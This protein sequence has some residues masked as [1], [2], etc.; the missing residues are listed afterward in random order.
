MLPK[1]SAA[2]RKCLPCLQVRALDSRPS[3]VGNPMCVTFLVCDRSQLLTKGQVRQY[4]N[5]R[6]QAAVGSMFCLM[7]FLRMMDD[8]MSSKTGSVLQLKV[9]L[10]KISPM[11][12]QRML[13][14]I[15]G[16]QALQ[17]GKGGSG[18]RDGGRFTPN[19]WV[20]PKRPGRRLSCVVPAKDAPNPLGSAPGI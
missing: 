3:I 13:A 17:R 9:R 2:R 4:R 11:I 6:G 16:P 15:L 7:K 8:K 1:K 14:P 20:L 12:W 18:I 5:L 19:S 10:A